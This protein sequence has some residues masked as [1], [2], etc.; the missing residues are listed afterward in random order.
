MKKLLAIMMSIIAS[1]SFAGAL[2]CPSVQAVQKLRVTNAEQ[3]EFFSGSLW[4]AY[5]KVRI[6]NDKIWELYIPLTEHPNNEQGAI[7]IGNQTLLRVAAFSGQLEENGE[8][9]CYYAAADKI[10]MLKTKHV[11]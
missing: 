4:A 5:A 6:D 9:I 2:D 8:T 10:V 3:G 11:R 1:H 7:D